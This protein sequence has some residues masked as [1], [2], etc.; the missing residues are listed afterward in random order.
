MIWNFACRIND[1]SCTARLTVSDILAFTPLVRFDAVYNPLFRA[2][3]K[4]LVD[5]P[6]HAAL[7]G[8]V[9]RPPDVAESVR[10]DHILMHYHDDDWGVANRRGIISRCPQVDFRSTMTAHSCTA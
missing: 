10:F 9:H 7:V 4:R 1:H 5:F 2:N 6:R 8:R 3:L